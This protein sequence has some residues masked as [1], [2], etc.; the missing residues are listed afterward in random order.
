MCLYINLL[1]RGD[2]NLATLQFRTLGTSVTAIV[3]VT[4]SAVQ[5]SVCVCVADYGDWGSGLHAT[6]GSSV[7]GKMG[8]VD[9][10]PTV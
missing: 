8:Q 9:T 6:A 3:N 5:I 4:D 7:H 10:K 2:K 1:F